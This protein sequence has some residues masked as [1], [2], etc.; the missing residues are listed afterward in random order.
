MMSAAD[1]Q[2]LAQV[3]GDAVAFDV[4]TARYTS[5]RVGGPADALATPPDRR[6]LAALLRACARRRIPHTVLGNGF[7]T[8]VRDGGLPGLAIR[9]NRFRGLEERP[10]SFLRAEAGVTHSAHLSSQATMCW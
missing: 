4:P 2:A 10:G 7:N 1:R 3:G 5:L 9:L 6:V 8:V